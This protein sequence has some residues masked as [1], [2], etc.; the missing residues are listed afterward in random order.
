MDVGD[1]VLNELEIMALPPLSPTM[2]RAFSEA[3]ADLSEMEKDDDHSTVIKLETLATRH[4]WSK[5]ED[6]ADS[7]S[8]RMA[9][10]TPST[11]RGQS[12]DCGMSPSKKDPATFKDT[13]E[14]K[15][16]RRS[17]I[18][19]KSRQRRQEM[20]KR[21]RAEVKQLEEVYAEMATRREPRTA[22]AGLNRSDAQ[23]RVYRPFSSASMGELQRKYSELSLVAHALEEDQVA[24]RELLQTHESSQQTVRSLS[25]EKEAEQRLWDSGIPQSSSFSVQYRHHSPGEC[26]VIVREAYQEI[27]RFCE[28]DNFETT[29][30]HFMGWTD[31]RKV[32]HELQA[33]QF[34]FTKRFPLERAEH[35]LM[36]T[37]NVFSNGAKMK[38]MAFDS[39][40]R[41]RFE[42][43]QVLNDNLIVIRRD[44][45][46]P[47]MPMTFASVQIIFR[48][49]TPTGYTMCS[50]TIPAP[51]IQ[52]ALEPHEYFYD[53]FHWYAIHVL[54]GLLTDKH[55][56]TLLLLF[57]V[58]G[59]ASTICTTN[60]ATAQGA[61]LLR[62]DLSKIKTSC[63]PGIGCSNSCAPFCAGSMRASRHC[64]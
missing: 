51:E 18:E 1:N 9:T 25:D 60:W 2:E 63:S 13:A 43:L 3:L 23:M 29:G 5:D 52:K 50:R 31:K 26:Y 22:A 61:K 20:L 49:E 35:L 6:D 34:C 16:A 48:L 37:W 17:A 28:V 33:L 41:T 45:K 46:I 59:H 14:A 24:L 11:S 8:V 62:V 54:Y 19:K 64:C 10:P 36:Q 39:S 55:F 57:V 47:T 38:E 15:R 27:E 4:D 58:T 12:E 30:A 32:D 56:L 44:H 42:V 53:A 21:M 7:T 40:V